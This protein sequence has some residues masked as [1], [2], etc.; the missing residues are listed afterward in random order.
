MN[1][2]VT[3]LNED[4]FHG[5]WSTWLVIEFPDFEFDWEYKRNVLEPIVRSV[6][7]TE[8]DME[9]D[10]DIEQGVAREKFV[11]QLEDAFREKGFTVNIQE[12]AFVFVGQ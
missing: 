4:G 5:D 10:E 1:K 11:G 8:Y 3:V 7:Y 2:L 9:A 12:A 6:L